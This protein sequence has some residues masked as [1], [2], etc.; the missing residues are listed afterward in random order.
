MGLRVRFLDV[1]GPPAGVG[2]GLLRR[3]LA[4]A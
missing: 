1:F 2:R 3:R 4:I